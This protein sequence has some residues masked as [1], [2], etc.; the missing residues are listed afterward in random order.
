MP[1]VSTITSGQ[2][3][4][5]D[6]R[7]E[8]EITG[9]IDLSMLYAGGQYIQ[10]GYYR[11][12][13]AAQA[14]ADGM[15]VN[16]PIPTSGPIS[17]ANFYGVKK[18][19]FIVFEVQKSAGQPDGVD[20]PILSKTE[21]LSTTTVKD[22]QVYY[23]TTDSKI[24]LKDVSTGTEYP[25]QKAIDVSD[26]RV[27]VLFTN[28][29]GTGNGTM[30]TNIPVTSTFNQT[31]TTSA[32][33]GTIS[34]RQ[35]VITIKDNIITQNTSSFTVTLRAEN[36]FVPLVWATI[37]S[38]AS[39]ATGLING[40]ITARSQIEYTTGVSKARLKIDSTWYELTQQT[41]VADRV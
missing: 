25:L 26:N 29:S 30:G 16:Q 10:A 24:V 3:T 20:I 19:P 8:F 41:T 28:L 36:T 35:I 33:I 27:S 2:I 34:N 14:L 18:L 6:I 12:A 22:I 38:L 32:G 7:S 37:P 5:D 21:R 40:T 1:K 17:L 23:R 31:I 9:P 11:S 4:L 15:A 39:S 13:A